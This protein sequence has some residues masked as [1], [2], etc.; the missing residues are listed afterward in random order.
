MVVP[1]HASAKNPHMIAF[2]VTVTIVSVVQIIVGQQP[3]SLSAAV[4]P[5]MGTIWSILCG[6][7]GISVLVGTFLRNPA[8]GL[9]VEGAGHFAIA[10]GYLAYCL[11]LFENL[12]SPWYMVVTF[13]WTAAFAIASAIRGYLI[14]RVIRKAKQRVKRQKLLEERGRANGS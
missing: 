4:S 7:G 3:P 11:A 5:P 1:T 2:A 13:W 8:S 12:N 6:L 10:T 9:M 14:N